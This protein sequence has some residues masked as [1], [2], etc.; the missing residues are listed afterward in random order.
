MNV[1]LPY[2]GARRRGSRHR[3]RRSGLRIEELL[4]LSPP[5]GSARGHRSAQAD[6]ATGDLEGSHRARVATDRYVA[7]GRK[8]VRRRPRPGCEEVEAL[9]PRSPP[10]TASTICS[11]S[12]R[13]TDP[14]LTRTRFM[15]G[16]ISRSMVRS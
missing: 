12:A 11:A 9:W 4:E 10:K 2:R 5:E 15:I 3:N 13:S 1:Q 16:P 8:A 7:I 6:G 14:P